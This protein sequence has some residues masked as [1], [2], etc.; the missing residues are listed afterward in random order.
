MRDTVAVIGIGS[1]VRACMAG[2]MLLCEIRAR[3]RIRRETI[4]PACGER[5]GSSCGIARPSDSAALRLTVGVYRPRLAHV[6]CTCARGHISDLLMAR[7]ARS[8]RAKAQGLPKACCAHTGLTQ[9]PQA[10]NKSPFTDFCHAA[11]R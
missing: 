5:E 8:D 9:P 4:L 10:Q 7:Y 2:F 1:R 6:T 11:R 3:Q